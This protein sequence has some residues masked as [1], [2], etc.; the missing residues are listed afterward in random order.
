MSFSPCKKIG[1][2]PMA[3]PGDSGFRRICRACG[4]DYTVTEMI[5]AKAIFHGARKTAALARHTPEEKPILIQLF[6]RDPE[7]MGY[8]ASF[9]RDTFDPAGIDLNMGCP[10]PKVFNNGDG[11]A[12]LAE[13]ALAAE[14][15]DAAVRGSGLPVS[16]KMR[17]GIDRADGSAVDFAKAVEAAGASFVTVHGR[18]RAQ[19]YSGRA[20]YGEIRRIREALSIPV[21]ANGDVTDGPS[22]A[23][24]LE[25]TGAAGI[26]LARG[27]LG[28]PDVFGRIKDYLAGNPGAEPSLEAR[29]S[30]CLK[31]LAYTVA[32]KGEERGCVEFR[33]HLLWYLK[34]IRHAA[35]YKTAAG[36]ISSV[37][38]CKALINRILEE[39]N[40]PRF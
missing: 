19:F 32:D 24:I 26:M 30:L 4:A 2:A 10:A 40:R 35:Q 39:E 38:D 18:T 3:G 1:L 34:G 13:P 22:A 5:S 23:R 28:S 20:D 7:A 31:Q 33:K 16:V 12:L 25:E 29:F 37:A 36:Q 15:V 17:I 6:G 11:S 14:L 27:A 8:A 21:I 9:V